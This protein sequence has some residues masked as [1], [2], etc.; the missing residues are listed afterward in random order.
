M[1]AKDHHLGS[2]AAPFG[3]NIFFA[4]FANISW[5]KS[6]PKN[7]SVLGTKIGRTILKFFIQL[8]NF[9]LS[10]TDRDNELY[11]VVF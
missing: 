10:N 11:V 3:T 9:F 2:V 8:L 4:R 7:W 5:N 6:R 1:D